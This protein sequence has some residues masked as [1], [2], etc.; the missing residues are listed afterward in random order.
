MAFALLEMDEEKID[1]FASSIS[2]VK[3]NIH[4]C[5]ICNNLTEVMIIH[6]D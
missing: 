5:P 1:V 4:R 6:S 3:E 2:K